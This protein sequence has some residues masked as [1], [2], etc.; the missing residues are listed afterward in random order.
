MD[1]TTL[2]IIILIVLILFGGGYFPSP[3][4]RK[5]QAQSSSVIATGP[6]D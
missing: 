5:A 1:T 6:G 3:D 4:H 2:L